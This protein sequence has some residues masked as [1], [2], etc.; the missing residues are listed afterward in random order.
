MQKIMVATDFS[1]RSDRALRRATL[2]AKQFGTTL[3]LVHAVDDDR[4][5]RI[6]EHE[7]AD[8]TAL[9]REQA[10]TLQTLD[11]VASEARVVLGAPAATL[12]QATRDIAPDLLVI[13]PHRRR[14]LRDVFVGTTAE[15]TI[16]AVACP[17]LMANAPPAGPYRHV[18]LT[19]DLSEGSREAMQVHA[20]LG[21]RGTV[22]QS[23]LHVFDAPA[24]RLAMAHAIPQDDSAEYL[25]GERKSAAG[26]LEEF[27][28][29]ARMGPWE[30]VLR[31]R[32]TTD[33]NE[34]LAAA[35]EI[36]ADLI[37]LATQGKRGVGKLLLGSVTEQVLRDS[38]IDVL[39]IPPAGAT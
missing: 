4:P 38:P 9:L 21:L 10:A 29:A 34:I 18:L 17:V 36:K 12:V 25:E 8:A 33:R 37:V 32:R 22:G 23:L 11:G 15:R 13:G 39:A 27:M 2:L 24:L 35:T 20:G 7:A 5:P 30:K 16:R 31:H 6:I 14:L 19:T 26:A 28:A 1:E 3:T